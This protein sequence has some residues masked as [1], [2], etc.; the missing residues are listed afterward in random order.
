MAS[1]PYTQIECGGCETFYR[2]RMRGNT[3]RCPECRTP[4]YVPTDPVWEGPDTT[5]TKVSEQPAQQRQAC[6]VECRSCGHQWLTRA[7]GGASI[8]C[9]GV[10]TDGQKCRSATW[11]P[12]DRNLAKTPTRNQQQPSP[13]NPPPVR[14]RPPAP[15]PTPR[16]I[17]PAASTPPRR[18]MM[19]PAAPVRRPAMPAPAATGGG[20]LG[21]LTRIGMSWPPP[22][23]SPTPAPRAPITPAVRPIPLTQPAVA[24]QPD[25]GWGGLPGGFL[26]AP[27]PAGHHDGEQKW[28][29]DPATAHQRLRALGME[30]ADPELWTSNGCWIEPQWGGVCGVTTRY[31]V[32]L[33]PKAYVNVCD[34]HGQTA[35][36][37]ASE[38]DARVQVLMR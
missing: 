9:P 38:R 28:G 6:P 10:L 23:A 11:V 37:L 29:T 15:A 35:S 7:R 19:P 21:M 18:P 30:L 32:R 3:T 1:G 26:G 20:L 36:R 27:R 8:R 14:Y 5:P 13:R 22:A 2:T 24:A 34:Q 25:A 16:V 12:V 31:T 17:R 4:R 33:T